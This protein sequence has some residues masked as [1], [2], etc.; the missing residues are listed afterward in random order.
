MRYIWLWVVAALVAAPPVLGATCDTPTVPFTAQAKR[1]GAPLNGFRRVK[2]L[3]FGSE[4][5]TSATR[6]GPGL[7]T[8]ATAEYDVWFKDGVGNVPIDAF[9]A[10]Q[11]SEA[12]EMGLEVDGEPLQNLPIHC[13]PRAIQASSATRA[14][15]AVALINPP[16]QSGL[17]Y[18]NRLSPTPID[19]SNL[20]WLEMD[21]LTVVAPADGYLWVE[22]NGQESFAGFAIECV[23]LRLGTSAP[24]D[25]ESLGARQFGPA[26]RLFSITN[27]IPV[28]AGTHVIRLYAK[29]CQ[30]AAEVLVF[31]FQAMWVPARY[32]P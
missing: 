3:L 18:V 31:N 2:F 15:S 10:T 7:R 22:A 24:S 25:L 12:A 20:F 21:N 6:V 16:A 26:E 5:R 14:D 8:L 4:P 9:N 19:T 17:S 29:S 32:Q 28:T 11:W 30:G 1:D 23:I 27:V 13:V